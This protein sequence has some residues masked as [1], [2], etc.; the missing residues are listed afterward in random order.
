ATESNIKSYYVTE[1]A[2]MAIGESPS[3]NILNNAKSLQKQV[4]KKIS[5]NPNI[6]AEHYII[7][8]GK[9]SRL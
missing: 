3:L 4:I 2:Q 9:I 7:K 1:L 6:L 5:K 8:D